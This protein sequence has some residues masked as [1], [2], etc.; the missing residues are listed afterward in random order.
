[1]TKSELGGGSGVRKKAVKALGRKVSTPMKKTANSSW[2]TSVSSGSGTTGTEKKEASPA[3]LN[4]RTRNKRSRK[5]NIR[6]TRKLRGEDK[7]TNNSEALPVPELNVK[8]A[9]FI[10]DKRSNPQV[11][12]K[13]EHTSRQKQGRPVTDTTLPETRK[14]LPSGSDKQK[15]GK[16]FKKRWRS[17]RQ[18]KEK[19]TVTAV[20]QQKFSKEPSPVTRKKVSEPDSNSTAK[21]LMRDRPCTAPVIREE[22]S[23]DPNTPATSITTTNPV[24]RMGRKGRKKSSNRGATLNHKAQTP[25]TTINQ[26]NNHRQRK[27]KSKTP[28]G[29][30]TRSSAN[31]AKLQVPPSKKSNSRASQKQAISNK[32]PRE[33]YFT[34]K[35]DQKDLF[36]QLGQ[37]RNYKQL[38]D[39]LEGLLPNYRQKCNFPLIVPSA[40]P[41][42]PEK[43]SSSQWRTQEKLKA[44]FPTSGS[45]PFTNSEDF[46][47]QNHSNQDQNLRPLST[48]SEARL[49]GP[50]TPSSSSASPSPEDHCPHEKVQE[51]TEKSDSKRNGDDE[52]TVSHLSPTPPPPRN[53]PS[54][55]NRTTAQAGQLAQMT[56]IPSIQPAPDS[57]TAND[58]SKKMKTKKLS[59]SAW[60]AAARPLPQ[61]QTATAEQQTSFF[62]PT[63][64]PNN[65]DPQQHNQFNPQNQALPSAID[66]SSTFLTP[67]VQSYGWSP[68]LMYVPQ[69]GQ[70]NPS[71]N[72]M[73]N[74]SQYNE[75]PLPAAA[76]WAFAQG[77]QL[78]FNGQPTYA[79]TP[80]RTMLT[81][82]HVET[83]HGL[84]PLQLYQQD[85]I[86]EVV[87]DFCARW[88]MND[89]VNRLYQSIVAKVVPH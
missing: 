41:S 6:L 50:I 84:V 74:N 48:K 85:N 15:S 79:Y 56:P 14:P 60:Q 42:M 63:S 8:D 59:D 88:G 71:Q 44:P 54:H 39:L 17:R 72:S 23:A 77:Q 62:P 12:L 21:H 70:F 18:S 35:S 46:S 52:E 25:A 38:I 67:P 37:T 7:T 11:S 65:D 34:F 86:M 81:V 22:S 20:N 87:R 33:K 82:M 76:Q 4:N 66:Y 30:Q 13:Q 31:S 73:I 68:Q 47:S 32:K 53:P 28:G 64:L 57:T 89:C 49:R 69:Q 43:I 19:E 10:S 27:H 75:P 45:F 1:M 24:N 16:P 55:K 51:V 80:N 78:G 2:K 40:M 58:P 29:K 36:A 83:P 5:T 26:Q 61:A 9:R 3:R